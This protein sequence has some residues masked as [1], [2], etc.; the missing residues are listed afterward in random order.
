VAVRVVQVAV[1]PHPT[2]AVEALEC[3]QDK[4]IQVHPRLFLV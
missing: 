1:L 3:H 4:D 2:V